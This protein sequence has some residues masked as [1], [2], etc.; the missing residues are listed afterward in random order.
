MPSRTRPENNSILDKSPTADIKASLGSDAVAICI[1]FAA[2]IRGLSF[3]EF[4]HETRDEA[5]A[6]LVERLDHSARLL[7]ALIGE[8]ADQRFLGLD[9]DLVE[10]GGELFRQTQILGTRH[11]AV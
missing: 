11:D 5:V 9:D 6:H 1:S 4:L 7:V 2:G 8:A 3:L 10:L